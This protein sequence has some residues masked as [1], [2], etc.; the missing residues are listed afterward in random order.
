MTGA[1]LKAKREAL[2]LAP[3]ELARALNM[4]VWGFRLIGS[5][6]SGTW[7]VPKYVEQWINAQPCRWCGKSPVV[8]A[9]DGDPLCQSCCDIWVIGER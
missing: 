8:S 1:E 9:F 6:E 3:S 4:D 7:P 2:G 5:Y